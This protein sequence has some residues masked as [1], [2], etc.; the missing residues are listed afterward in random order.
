M[1]LEHM[2]FKIGWFLLG[3]ILGVLVTITVFGA[4][5]DSPVPSDFRL[6]DN[7][8]EWLRVGPKFIEGIDSTAVRISFAPHEEASL[9]YDKQKIADIKRWIIDNNFAD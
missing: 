9:I 8:Q 2:G 6:R 4:F 3:C 1:K 7:G 5:F